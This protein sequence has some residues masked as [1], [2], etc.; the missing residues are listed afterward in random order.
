MAFFTV[1]NSAGSLGKFFNEVV[2]VSSVK[3]E[4]TGIEEIKKMGDVY[5]KVTFNEGEKGEVYIIM[6]N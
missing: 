4:I 1:C 5:S 6:K 3:T 2:S